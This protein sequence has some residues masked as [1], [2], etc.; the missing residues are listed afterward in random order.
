[1]YGCETWSFTLTKERRLKVLDNRMLR[2]IFGSKEGEVTVKWGEKLLNEELNNLYSSPNIV[3]VVKSRRMSWTG[4]VAR[5][6]E[7]RDMYGVLA[8]IPEEKR[9]LG[10]TKR[11]WEDLQEV[12]CGTSWL[13]IG[14][15]GVHL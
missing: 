6:G 9:P 8:G 5:I 2:R 14:T 7:R 3:R 11:S 15:G 1:M 12:G 10:R 13:G 4:H